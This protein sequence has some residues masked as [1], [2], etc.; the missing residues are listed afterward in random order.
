MTDEK[1]TQKTKRPRRLYTAE[2]KDAA[3]K[4]VGRGELSIPR[5][6]RD[7]GISDSLLRIWVD[8]AKTAEDG[9]L[10]S[11]ERFELARLRKENRILKEEREIL[12]KAATFFAKESR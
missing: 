3:V 10:S 5:V 1:P 8:K 12:K 9:G 4:L 2:F 11:D 6:A 7:L